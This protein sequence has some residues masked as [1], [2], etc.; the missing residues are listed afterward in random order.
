MNKRRKIM[1]DKYKHYDEIVK[2][3]VLNIDAERQ[4]VGKIILWDFHEEKDSD[5]LYFNVAAVVSDIKNEL[6]YVQMP[7][8]PYLKMKWK[9]RKT[10]KNLRRLG[11]RAAK[12]LPFQSQTSIG[13]IMEFVKNYHK[14][15][16]E[17][18]TEINN[19]YY[20]WV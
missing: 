5:K 14:E 6:M 7:L 9:R 12:S 10:R 11:W 15:T 8:I 18:F 19:E 1:E 13:V 4:R 20:G 2:T 16:D 3:I 17:I